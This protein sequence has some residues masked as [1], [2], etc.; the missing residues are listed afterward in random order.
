MAA[1]RVEFTAA[2]IGQWGTPARYSADLLKVCYEA[3]MTQRFVFE[4]G[5]T[6]YL[7]TR[8]VGVDDVGIEGGSVPAGYGA[9]ESRDADGDWLSGW[10]D[11]LDTGKSDFGPDADK[12]IGEFK[13]HDGTGKW[14]GVSGTVRA[15]LWALPEDMEAAWPPTAPAVFHGFLEGTGELDVPNLKG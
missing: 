13:W 3:K 11:W 9:I 14:A 4:G 7:K 10:L 1:R 6:I 8:F 5:P 15:E 12:W 2:G